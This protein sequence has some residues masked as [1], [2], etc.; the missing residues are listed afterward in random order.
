MG[1]QGQRFPHFHTVLPAPFNLFCLNLRWRECVPAPVS[2]RVGW[3]NKLA[4]R[5]SWLCVSR[6][7]AGRSQDPKDPWPRIFP[8]SLNTSQVGLIWKTVRLWEQVLEV[9]TPQNTTSLVSFVVFLRLWRGFHRLRA[10]QSRLF[11]RNGLY[12]WCS[13]RGELWSPNLPLSTVQQHRAFPALCD[14][15]TTRPACLPSLSAPL[16]RVKWLSSL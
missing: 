10:L 12:N 8:G 4:E 15:T 14:L 3:P 16:Q 6:Q 13:G 2:A 7:A 9:F 1:S 11:L 5:Q